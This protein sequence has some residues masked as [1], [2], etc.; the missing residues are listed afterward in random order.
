MGLF[1]PH[2][3]T[4][5]PQSAVVIDKS[6][7]LTEG[8]VCA[9]LP[10][11]GAF[12]DV[13]TGQ[14]STQGDT[15]NPTSTVV[16]DWQNG[17]S[18]PDFV[19]AQ[20]NNTSGGNTTTGQVFVN[21]TTG[22]DKLTTKGTLIA[23]GGMATTNTATYTMF[24]SSEFV[25]VGTGCAVG[26]DNNSFQGPGRI[27]GHISNAAQSTSFNIGNGTDNELTSSPGNKL[28]T[29]G[30]GWDGT[31]YHWYSAGIGFVKQSNAGTLSPVAQ[32]NRK[33][34]VGRG[35]QS[36]ALGGLSAFMALGLA[37]N[38]VLSLAEYIQLWQNPWAVFKT[39][40]VIWVPVTS[41]GGT[42]YSGTVSET[43]T[44]ADTVSAT[45]IFGD[46]V[47]E[48]LAAID[49]ETGNTVVS[50]S[51]AETLAASETVTASSAISVDVA[52]TL[53]AADTVST[54]VI[55]SGTVAEVLA[56]ADTPNATAIMG[57]SV[58]EVLSAIETTTGNISGGGTPVTI[59]GGV[60]AYD[61]LGGVSK[62]TVL[63]V[64]LGGGLYTVTYTEGASENRVD[65]VHNEWYIIS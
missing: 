43:L 10:V 42:T 44:A 38:R 1:L 11:G 21:N 23:V 18:R 46:S 36:M 31:N 50:V 34:A 19:K 26:I 24:G 20:Q 56:A 52:E 12:L 14:V 27:L 57:V 16:R 47:A 59:L 15:S 49:S 37:W 58:A 41:G 29:F 7:P 6:N 32:S 5:Q 39:P 65:S 13:F 64:D 48:T 9:L 28:H 25:S 8:M 53:T 45:A 63:L 17:T 60:S 22:V 55:W 62:K 4:Q 2:R 61:G 51:V 35:G 54:T 33:T 40:Q 30:L 3:F